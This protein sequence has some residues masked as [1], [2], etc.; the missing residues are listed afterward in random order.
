M[1]GRALRAC[2]GETRGGP[3][4][5]GA[6][7][8]A[9]AQCPGGALERR[10]RGPCAGPGVG[11]ATAQSPW[12]RLLWGR[13]R[14]G[15]GF[16]A[17]RALDEPRRVGAAAFSCR[18]LRGRTRPWWCFGAASTLHRPRHRSCHCLRAS[19]GFGFA[20]FSRRCVF[21]SLRFRVAAFS[22]RRLCRTRPAWC[23]AARTW[24]LWTLQQ[25]SRC[26]FV[27][28][29]VR[30]HNALVVFWSSGV[31]GR[32]RPASELFPRAASSGPAP[33]GGG[34]LAWGNAVLWL[35]AMPAFAVRAC[36]RASRAVRAGRGAFPFCAKEVRWSMAARRQ[37]RSARG[38]SGGSME[39]RRWG[40]V[41]V[42]GSAGI[43]GTVASAASA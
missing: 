34:P 5:V 25:G 41:C 13:T 4:T 3:P 28:V 19:V 11:A 38:R 9:A 39:R 7:A 24:F 12:C 20:A 17:A 16:G 29:F 6:R 33:G 31:G 27:S 30:R 15:R 21:A 40:S 8:R 14:A 1:S 37:A 2:S 22:R 18:F 10:V 43:A 32:A 35:G 23:G 36:A 26:V 42:G